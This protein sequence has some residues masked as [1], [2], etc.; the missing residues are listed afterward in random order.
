MSTPFA[1]LRFSAAT[2]E[3]KVQF[4]VRNRAFLIGAV[5]I[6]SDFLSISL[7]IGAALACSIL[8]NSRIPS[9]PP[10]VLLLPIITVALFAAFGHYP[11]LGLTA[12]CQLRNMCRG[13]AMVYLIFV[14]SLFLENELSMDSRGV[15][16]LACAFSWAAVPLARWLMRSPF[17][18]GFQWGVPVVIVGAGKTGRRVIRS[19]RMNQILGYRPAVCVDDDP[20]KRGYCEGV[21]VVGSLLDAASVA[22]QVGARLAILA[23]PSFERRQLDEYLRRWKTSLPRILMVPD[24]PGIGSR[25]TESQ[26]LGGL[27]GFEIERPPLNL[28]NRILKRAVDLVGSIVGLAMAAPLVACSVLAIKLVSPGSAFYAQERE[29]QGRSIFRVFKLRTMYPGA[30]QMLRNHLAADP[31]A[32]EQWDHSCK[33]K[34]DPRIL[35]V[36]GRFLRSTSLDELPQLWNVLRGEMTLVGPR[37]F[38]AYHNARFD[39]DFRA[40][41]TQVKPGLTGLWQVSARTDGDLTVQESLDA[42]YIRNWSAWLDLFILIHTVR[43]V[44]AREGS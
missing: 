17:M 26:D 2:V 27:L 6:A 8:V 13:I 23:I 43:A 16:L 32:R 3:S 12:V 28:W 30:E 10:T 22:E 36:V 25:W 11:G 37:P 44:F 1:E 29:G 14:S 33:L 40:L 38:P 42:Y 9:L 7:A 35:P 19:L 24:L 41:R 20:D 39:S 4:G 34:N 21:P 15:L 5:T 18:S 31:V